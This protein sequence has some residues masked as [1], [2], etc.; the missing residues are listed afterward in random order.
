MVTIVGNRGITKAGDGQEFFELSN[1]IMLENLNA[2]D[3]MQD[4]VVF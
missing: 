4:F 1:A 3:K 2:L